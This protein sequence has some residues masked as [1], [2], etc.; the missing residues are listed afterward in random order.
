MVYSNQYTIYIKLPILQNQKQKK[1]NLE[2]MSKVQV[3]YYKN[4]KKKAHLDNT[5]NSQN[6]ILWNNQMA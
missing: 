2:L 6:R 3:Y 5:C 4:L 1:A